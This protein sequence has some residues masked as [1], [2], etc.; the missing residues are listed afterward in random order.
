VSMTSTV[1]PSKAK[2][3]PLVRF[4]AVVSAFVLVNA[5]IFVAAR[6]VVGELLTPLG[7]LISIGGGISAA[8][9]IGSLGEWLVHR[10]FM[11]RRLRPR[12]LNLAYDL[13]HRAHH[14]IQYPPN[15]YLHDDRVQRVPVSPHL[16]RVC[17]T[18]T[19]RALTVALHVAFY[20]TFGVILAVIPSLVFTG[21]PPF[22]LVVAVVTM[23]EIFL[24]VHV[25]D[26][27][28]HPG[29]SRLE[30]FRWFRFLDRHHYIHH[31]D[32]KANTNFLLPLCDLLMGVLRR[33]LS[34]RELATWPSYEE[35]RQNVVRPVFNDRG[36]RVRDHTTNGDFGPAAGVNTSSARKKSQ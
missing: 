9:L 31:V 14:W 17:I 6:S 5:G 10:Y 19:E 2:D 25:H 29:F 32:N 34:P 20:S 33:N 30:R 8:L 35:A 24:F 15:E 28:Q 16:E 4:A 3:P 36:I 1:A 7:L 12:P 18:R 22:T 13:H 27:V 11:H 21:N 23:T 26:A